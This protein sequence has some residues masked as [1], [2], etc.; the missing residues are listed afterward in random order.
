MIACGK[1]GAQAGPAKPFYS[2]MVA[3]CVGP[4]TVPALGM[5]NGGN[6]RAIVTLTDGWHTNGVLHVI[7]AVLDTND[8]T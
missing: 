5:D 8:A 4:A 3:I 2:H 6:R 1:I 7:D